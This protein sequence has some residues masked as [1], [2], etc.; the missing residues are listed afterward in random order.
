MGSSPGRG[1]CFLLHV[2][3]LGCFVCAEQCKAVVVCGRWFLT[4]SWGTPGVLG[5]SELMGHGWGSDI[6]VSSWSLALCPALPAQL[7]TQGLL[8]FS[9]RVALRQFSS[10]WRSELTLGNPET[11]PEPNHATASG[12]VPGLCFS[13]PSSLQRTAELHTGFQRGVPSFVPRY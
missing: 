5:T 12:C 2:V 13:F 1:P 4:C 11:F 9:S 8:H 10:S 3:R 6:P 7:S